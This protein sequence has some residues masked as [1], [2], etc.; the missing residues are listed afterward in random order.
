[1][2]KYRQIYRVYFNEKCISYYLRCISNNLS[3]YEI[4][5]KGTKNNLL[6]VQPNFHYSINKFC[7]LDWHVTGI[8]KYLFLD[9]LKFPVF[10]LLF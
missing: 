10:F 3:F 4:M 8:L 2:Q 1:M 5:E 9:I 7:Y 6:T